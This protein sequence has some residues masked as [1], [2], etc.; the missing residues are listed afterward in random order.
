MSSTSVFRELLILEN[1][2]AVNNGGC[3]L[4]FMS[5]QF[6]LEIDY[7]PGLSGLLS[8]HFKMHL[9]FLIVLLL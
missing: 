3:S 1:Y 6:A 7:W 4:V 8:V 2:S 5:L 9:N